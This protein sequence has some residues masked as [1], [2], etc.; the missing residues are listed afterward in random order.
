MEQTKTQKMVRI[1]L[2]KVKS[3]KLIILPTN[4]LLQQVW[5]YLLTRPNKKGESKKDKHES[6]FLLG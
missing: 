2:E 4:Q 3:K 6:L 1:M 5:D